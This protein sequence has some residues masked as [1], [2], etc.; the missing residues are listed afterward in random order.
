LKPFLKTVGID[1]DRLR[2]EWIGASEGLKVVE[3]VKSFTQTIKN[4]GPSQLNRSHNC[5]GAQI[6]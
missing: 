2:L 5:S 4:L 3:T 1:S 6:C